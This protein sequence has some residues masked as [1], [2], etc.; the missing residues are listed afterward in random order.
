M[1]LQESRWV[2]RERKWGDQDIE[3][4]HEWC[5]RLEGQNGLV[6]RAGI[7]L[8][9]LFWC[10]DWGNEGK[11]ACFLPLTLPRVPQSFETVMDCQLVGIL[12]ASKGGSGW[13][14]FRG[15]ERL[16]RSQN[17]SGK[18]GEPLTHSYTIPSISQWRHGP[19][20]WVRISTHAS[21]RPHTVCR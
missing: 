10:V 16:C 1:G 7:I 9:G 13:A 14:S 3:I 21:C 2:R 18:W 15:Y 4:G 12:K 17:V 20:C 8:W 5:S 6:L 11:H 19:L